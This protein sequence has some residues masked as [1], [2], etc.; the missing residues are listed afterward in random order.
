ML[1]IKWMI[2]TTKKQKMSE[3]QNGASEPVKMTHKVSIFLPFKYLS[4]YLSW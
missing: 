4:G 2:Q 3:A 1:T